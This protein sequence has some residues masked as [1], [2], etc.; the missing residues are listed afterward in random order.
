MLDTNA[1]IQLINR[2]HPPLTKRIVSHRAS[3]FALS[4]VTAAELFFGVENSQHRAKSVKR[5]AL[6]LAEIEVLAFD[7]R[8][9][10]A[11]GAI[12][13]SLAQRGTPIGPLDNLIAAHAVAAG[14]TLVTTNLREFQRV[15][16][17]KVENWSIP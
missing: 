9:A 13:A 8:A 15:K 14:L 12:R 3:D 2:S 10:E 4:A 5:L 1:C 17:L 6:L 16:S 11:Y 7:E